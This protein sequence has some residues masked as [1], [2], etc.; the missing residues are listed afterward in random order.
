MSSRRSP[1]ALVHGPARSSRPLLSG[2]G[3]PAID[4]I[5]QINEGRVTATEYA[6]P[7]SSRRSGAGSSQII[8]FG[9]HRDKEERIETFDI[10]ID[11]RAPP[12]GRSPS[13]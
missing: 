1:V 5:G 8:V 11:Q 4:L 6:V 13:I 7:G 12:R 3:K 9:R 10:N 2:L